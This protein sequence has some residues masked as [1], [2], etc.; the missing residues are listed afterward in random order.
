MKC[1]RDFFTEKS[2][3]IAKMSNLRSSYSMLINVRLF[4]R[5]WLIVLRRTYFILLSL[6]CREAPESA[7]PVASATAAF[8]T[9]LIRHCL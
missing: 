2:L 3:M 7:R 1:L 5:L 9:L 8:A 6:R 4:R